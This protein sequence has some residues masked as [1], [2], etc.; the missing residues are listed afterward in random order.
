MSLM[1]M[2]AT[3]PG[4]Q[5]HIQPLSPETSSSLQL[6]VTNNIDEQHLQCVSKKTSRT[7]LAVTLESIVGFS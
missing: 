7:F 1:S 5:G 6:S 4:S 3:S 2:K